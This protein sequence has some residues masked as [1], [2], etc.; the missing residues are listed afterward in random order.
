MSISQESKFFLRVHYPALE[1]DDLK[2]QEKE[3]LTLLSESEH[4]N[5]KF[6][7]HTALIFKEQTRV[8][9]LRE[10]YYLNLTTLCN[11]LKGMIFFVT[12]IKYT[13]LNH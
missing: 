7:M 6:P 1:I 12:K 9:G 2:I 10:K 13:T 11:T 4:S 8:K 3:A 5:I